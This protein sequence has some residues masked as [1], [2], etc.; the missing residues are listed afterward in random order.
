MQTNESLQQIGIEEIK[1]KIHEIHGLKV[2]L[3]RDLAELYQVEVGQMNR[4][5]KRNTERF[6]EDFRF[7]LSKEEWEVLKC[8]IGI[9]KL[10][11]G[12]RQLPY[13]FTEQGVS[14]LSGILRTPF[15]IQMNICIMRAFV[16]MRHFITENAG[17][18][19]RL[20]LV[21]KHQLETDIKINNILDG[22]EDGTLQEKAHIFSAGQIYEAKAFITEL[23]RNAKHRIILV[24]GYISAPTID[25]LHARQ[26]GVETI[27]YTSGVG[28][29]L[30]LLMKQY[31]SQYPLKKLEIKKWVTEQHDRWIIID[32]E[33]WH[34]GASIRDAG[35]KTFGIDRIGLNARI[36][37]DQL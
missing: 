2:M 15:A 21:E 9:S 6:P 12:D 16:S 33:L 3:D 35:I 27:I 31:N 30:R 36:I 28:A 23:I 34:C 13:A 1:T 29:N 8:Q 32:D 20:D 37:L 19:Q 14:A 11:G 10:R 5:V 26:D 25:L 7:Q 4:Q 18:F 24:D 22:L 17:I